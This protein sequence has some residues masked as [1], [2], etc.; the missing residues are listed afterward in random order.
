MRTRRD[1][2]TP[3]DETAEIPELRVI[4]DEEE[5][6]ETSREWRD[7]LLQPESW[8]EVL[9]TFASAMKLAVVMT[10]PAGRV[11]GKYHNPQPTWSL[12]RGT[13][14]DEGAGCPF[15]LTPSEPCTAAVDALRTGKVATAEDGAGLAH[16]AVP[17]ILRGRQLGALLGGQVFSRYPDLLR[18]ERVARRHAVSSQLL[19][20][21]AVRQVPTTR[22]SLKLYGD[23]LLALGDAFLGQR[24][25]VILQR[26]LA[27]TSQR[28][29]LFIDGVKDYALMTVDR[30]G[31]VKAWNQGAE[32]M[33]GYTE[34]EMLGQNSSRLAAPEAHFGDGLQEAIDQADRLGWTE[35]EVWRIRK[36]GTRFLGAGILASMGHGEAREYGSLMRDVTE[37]RRLEHDLQQ[38]QKLESIGVLAGGIAHDFNNLLTGIIG[39]LS[40][41]RASLPLN[42]PASPILEIAEQSGKRAAELVAQ[43]L[44]YAGKGKFV[45]TGFDLSKLI[46]D[47]LPLLSASIPKAVRLELAL[48]SDLPWVLADASQIRQ[49][50]MNLIINGAESIGSAG[51]VVNVSTWVAGSGSDVVMAVRDSGSG[52]NETTKAKIFEPFFTTKM[53][54]RGLGLAAVSGIV[55]SHKGTLKVD[56]APGRGTTF[57]VSFPA[58][59]PLTAAPVKPTVAIGPLPAT[60]IVLIVDDE[61]M[62]RKLAAAILTNAGCSVLVAEN[63]LEGVEAFR[64]NQSTILAVLL[65]M[66]MPVMAGHEAFRLIR[67]IRP[68]VP[69][70]MSSGYDEVEARGELGSET[71]ARFLRKPYT[72]ADLVACVQG[73]M[74]ESDKLEDLPATPR[75]QAP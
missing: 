53:T 1:F 17:L 7:E 35:R 41:V 22:A 31:V 27:Q 11:L 21:A 30:T 67:E 49:I 58:V 61:P 45:V 48:K 19:W 25:A 36:D 33:F 64:Q 51:G 43:L 42:D 52:M 4:S 59:E 28:Y 10:D 12:A 14:P 71:V 55:R 3:A 29:R 74:Q 66:T 50:V 73:I 46:A 75:E 34:A 16:V 69:I 38:S 72:A 56:S 6:L 8:S 18:L 23:L 20:Q 32:R 5:R 54:G 65:D 47:M 37:L 24:H 68:D 15:C 62:V 70:I 57:T 9:E 40:V 2:V 60:G 39:G 63:G 44:A 26:K 13:W